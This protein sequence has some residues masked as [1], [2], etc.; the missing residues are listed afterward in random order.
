[1]AWTAGL[2]LN[3]TAGAAASTLAAIINLGGAATP[4]VLGVA[5]GIP[6]MPPNAPTLDPITG[7]P[8]LGAAV[9]L[10]S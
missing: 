6:S 8:L 7:T 9:V 5:R 2:A 4:G 1:M 3:L 10:S